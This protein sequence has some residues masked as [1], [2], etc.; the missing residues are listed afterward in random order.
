[1]K[2]TQQGFFGKR[3]KVWRRQRSGGKHLVGAIW[4]RGEWYNADG[5]G[6]INLSIGNP[7]VHYR[8]AFNAYFYYKGV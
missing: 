8:W 3:L 7:K 5:V 1:M 2:K 6:Y 4:A